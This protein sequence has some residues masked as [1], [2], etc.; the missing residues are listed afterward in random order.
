[1]VNLLSFAAAIQICKFALYQKIRIGRPE[2]GIRKINLVVIV[3]N[4]QEGGGSCSF[5]K[6]CTAKYLLKSKKRG[7]LR[8]KW[9]LLLAKVPGE[10]R[11]T[12]SLP[13]NK[14]ISQ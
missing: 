12:F 5:K 14:F 10:I 1:L 3:S 2:R 11:K 13:K 8:K 9:N 7:K 4:V 6:G